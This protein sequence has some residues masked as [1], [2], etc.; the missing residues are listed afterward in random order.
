MKQTKKLRGMV[1]C[2]MIA[3]IYAAVSLAVPALSFGPV[4]MRIG[5]ALTLMP[6]LFPDSIL[7]VTIG[8]AITNAIGFMTGSN[9]LGVIDI[10]V[11]TIA[12]L[13][14]A[15]LTYRFRN[16]RLFD[17]PIVS[18]LM[19]VVFNAVFIGAEL[20]FLLSDGGFQLAVFIPQAISVG[21][22]E[23]IACFVLGLPLVKALEKTN[24]GIK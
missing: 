4:Q 18:A 13:L 3:G 1:L 2:G 8:C 19:P 12:T 7:G 24:I 15:I 10:P 11:G 21:F 16:I 5:E 22:G 17:L 9:I 23:L 6:I 14:A 20:G